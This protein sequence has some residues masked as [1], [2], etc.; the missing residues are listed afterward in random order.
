MAHSS[1]DT[2]VANQK[3]AFDHFA[4]LAGLTLNS[5]EKLA[6]HQ[7]S[8][9]RRALV[10][11]VDRSKEALDAKNLQQIFSLQDFLAQSP[12]EHGIAYYRGIYD[13]SAE[14]QDEYIKLLE[15]SHGEL[16]KTISS[17]LDWYSKSSANSDLAVAAVK[18]AL[19]AANSA[20]ENANKAVRQVANVAEASVSATARAV[21][22]ASAP[23][24]K[25]A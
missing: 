4:S 8:N 24:K 18:S 11:Q 15:R 17:I 21:D 23:R 20:F 7:L 5:I 10:Q 12:V 19:S 6:S 16:N 22:V 14:A 1:L 3:A 2:V 9:A 13:I 25:A